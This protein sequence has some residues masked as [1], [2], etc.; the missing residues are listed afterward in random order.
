MGKP[1]ICI[2]ENK[3]QISCAVTAQ[4]ISAFV[5]TIPLLL[6]SKISSFLPSSMSVQPG[7][8]QT[9]SETQIVGLSRTGS[10]VCVYGAAAS[11]IYLFYLQR[12]VYTRNN[13]IYRVRSGPTAVSTTVFVR[14][15]KLADISVWKS[16]IKKFCH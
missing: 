10:I 7:L 4:L 8:C 14:T 9:W 3:T 15:A 5:S 12:C 2:G 11:G 13:N 6:V 1:T 16:K